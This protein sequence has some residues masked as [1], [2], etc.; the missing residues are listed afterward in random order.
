MTEYYHHLVT[1]K[2]FLMLQDLQRR[3]DFIL[4]GGWAV[5]FYTKSLKSKDIDC[6]VDHTVLQR[7]RNDY[8]LVK[9]ERLQKYEIHME[10][11]DV[12]IYVRHYSDLGIPIEVIE[13]NTVRQEGFVLP[14]PEV[15][16]LLKQ[17][18]Y[19]D[20]QGTPKGEKDRIDIMSLLAR[21][22]NFDWSFY[23]KMITEQRCP[24]RADALRTLLAGVTDV[25]ELNLNQHQYSRMKK[26]IIEQLG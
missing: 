9:N 3:F 20:R 15:L 5:F 4:I 8:T 25:P 18:A 6:I 26:S 7:L 1:D 17:K 23:K 12:D 24:A 11:I 13:H 21:V 2:S 19:M 16:L 22:E 14:R 10:E